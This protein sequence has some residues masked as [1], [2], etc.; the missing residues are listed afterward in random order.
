VPGDGSYRIDSENS[1]LE[2]IGRNLNNRHFGRI[3]GYLPDQAGRG[4]LQR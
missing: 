4:W 3:K 1:R 2:W